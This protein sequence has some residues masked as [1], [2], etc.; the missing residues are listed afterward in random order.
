MRMPW[1][2]GKKSIVL[3]LPAG[4]GDSI[5]DIAIVKELLH[6]FPEIKIRT[7]HPSLF[8]WIP[9]VTAEPWKK[10][11]EDITA[12]YSGRK[13]DPQTNQWQDLLIACRLDHGIPFKVEWK[14]HNQKIIDRV[15]ESASGR[16]ICIVASPHVVFGRADGYGHELTPK[17]ERFDEIVQSMNGKMFFVEVGLTKMRSVSGCDLSLVG[18]V[19]DTDTMDL[20]SSCDFV[21]GQHGY[22][23][24]LAEAFDKPLFVVYSERGLRSCDP[25]IRYCTAKKTF[26]KPT[27]K[28]AVDN[29]P[30]KDIIR[31]AHECFAIQ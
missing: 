1:P 22:A 4:W 12:H 23:I 9:G 3:R 25:Y 16:P 15:K 6:Q 30:S 11:G 21:L 29:E 31:K 17:W 7:R 5:Y 18:K 2:Y 19:S 28:Y 14:I 13:Q 10:H 20:A 8:T 27:S 24:P 26:S